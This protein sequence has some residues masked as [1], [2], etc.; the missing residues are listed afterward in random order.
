MENPIGFVGNLVTAAKTLGFQQFAANIGKHLKASLLNW[1]LGSLEGHR[2]ISRKLSFKG[3]SQIWLLFG[4]DL[5]KL[6]IKLV[7]HLGEPAVKALE[8][9]FEIIQILITEGPAAAW[10]KIME[11]LSNSAIHKLFRKS[12]SLLLYR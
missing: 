6:R 2:C 1:L 3:D 12:V 5:G 7:K 10:E 4:I 8:A 9:G 11:H